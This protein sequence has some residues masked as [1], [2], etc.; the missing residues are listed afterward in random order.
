MIFHP[1]TLVSVLA[2]ALFCALTA[3]I[4]APLRLRAKNVIHFVLYNLT[5]EQHQYKERP[6]ETR[7]IFSGLAALAAFM[8]IPLGSL[9]ALIPVSWSGA[10]AVI[11]LALSA[12]L[13][14]AAGKWAAVF[15]LSLALGLS[16]LYARQRGV[17]GDLLAF[18]TYV[19]MP[20]A[21]VME[22]PGRAGL[23]TAGFAVLFLIGKTYRVK[24]GGVGYEKKD[25]ACAVGGVFTRAENGTVSD[26]DVFLREWADEVGRLAALGMWVCIFMPAG[27]AGEL[28]VPIV[29]GLALDAVYFWG[30]LA[31]LDYFASEINKML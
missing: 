21:H 3:A 5:T 6:K 22:W 23:L 7:V 19:G 18:E 4:G 24:S 16:A 17:P 20:L 30:K 13:R 2:Y 31:C 28:N 14:P 8:C 12:A 15:G 11:L 26:Y 1:L 9:P 25:D 27:L 29:A 10:L